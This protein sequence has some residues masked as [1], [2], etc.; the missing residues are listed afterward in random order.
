VLFCTAAEPA[1]RGEIAK[2]GPVIAKPFR[3]NDMERALAEVA[4]T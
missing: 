3:L 2:L 4:D 1:R